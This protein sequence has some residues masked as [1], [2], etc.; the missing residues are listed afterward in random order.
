M[1]PVFTPADDMKALRRA[2]VAQEKDYQILTVSYDVDV[3]YV[4]EERGSIQ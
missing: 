3:S 2:I 4:V 1:S